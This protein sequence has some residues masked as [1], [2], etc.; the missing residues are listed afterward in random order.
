MCSSSDYLFLNSYIAASLNTD[1]WVLPQIHATY[2]SKY[3]LDDANL[4][5][6][7]RLLKHVL[8]QKGLANLI[9]HDEL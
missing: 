1:Y 5:A 3:Q 9:V 7:I 8:A 6:L 2:R 4:D